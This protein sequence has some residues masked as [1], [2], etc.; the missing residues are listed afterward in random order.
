MNV[1]CVRFVTLAIVVSM[2]SVLGSS[3]GGPK[4]SPELTI[5]G[6]A[7][8]IWVPDETNGSGKLAKWKIIKDDSAPSKSPVIAIT[9]NKNKGQTYN[10]LIAQDKK[11]NHIELEAK[12]KAISGKEDQGGGL[13]WRVQDAANYYLARWNPLEENVRLYVVQNGRRRQ[14]ASAD[15]TVDAT[16]WHEL[17]IEQEE[18]DIE[19]EFGG[20]TLIAL[21]DE[22]FP[23]AGLVG[24]WT[25]ADAATAFTEL[26]VDTTD[27]W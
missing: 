1:R 17:E 14:L 23:E 15:V 22:T 18:T 3:C 13:I 7:L 19:I 2:L 27:D 16:A 8:K 4:P 24:L 5:P 21:K 6:F 20:K 12:I 25:K 11:Y 26:Y 9:K 10:L